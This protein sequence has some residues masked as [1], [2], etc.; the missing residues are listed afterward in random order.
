MSFSEKSIRTTIFALK[1]FHL[2]VACVT[3]LIILILLLVRHVPFSLGTA[4][5]IFL[6]SS[7]IF[8]GLHK[9]RPWVIILIVASSI[10]GT[11]N[12]FFYNPNT[13][14]QVVAKLV[15]IWLNIFH[16][17]FFSR[18][19]VRKYFDMKGVIIF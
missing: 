14:I 10:I 5:L 7:A 9:R 11:T 1:W 17:Y 12:S 15:G 16:L 4:L 13:S 8:F 18:K 3:A 19:E 6:Q 2:L